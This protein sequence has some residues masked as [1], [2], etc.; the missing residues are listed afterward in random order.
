MIG[1]QGAVL[2][3]KDGWKD[4]RMEGGREEERRHGMVWYGMVWGIVGMTVVV[5]TCSPLSLMPR[6]RS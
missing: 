4:G 3:W 5:G 6:P 1:A 2:G